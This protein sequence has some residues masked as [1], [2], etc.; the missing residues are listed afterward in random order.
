MPT[1]TLTN[2]KTKNVNLLQPV[3]PIEFPLKHPKKLFWNEV[4]TIVKKKYE[5]APINIVKKYNNL[6]KVKGFSN[7]GKECLNLLNSNKNIGIIRITKQTKRDKKIIS[8]YR[9]Q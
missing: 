1:Y 4:Y 8:L 6:L 5:L 3:I 7:Q 9:H 2:T